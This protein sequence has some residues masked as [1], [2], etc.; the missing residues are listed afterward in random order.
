MTKIPLAAVVALLFVAC[1]AASGAGPSSRF[2][3]TATEKDH[4]ITMRVGQKLE[5]ALHSGT[6]ASWQQAT[7]SDATILEPIPDPAA[8]TVQGVRLAAF[9]ADAAGH[10]TITAVGVPVCPS[11]QACPMY[12]LLY[13]L[14][15]T[16]TP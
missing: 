2:D 15:V 1:G 14:A 3:V 6:T 4:S 10:A 11:G 13:S 9:K 16:V 5:V 12:A 8:T 7:S